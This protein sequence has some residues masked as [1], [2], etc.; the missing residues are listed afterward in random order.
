M[1]PKRDGSQVFADAEE[2]ENT[3]AQSVTKLHQSPIAYDKS[4]VAI[5]PS[6]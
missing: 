4:P 6:R 1:S 2:P 5:T 3:T